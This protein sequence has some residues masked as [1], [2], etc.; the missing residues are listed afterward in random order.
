MY[1]LVINIILNFNTKYI[2]N[3]K[4][5]NHDSIDHFRSFE[6]F[7]VQLFKKS[8]LYRNYILNEQNH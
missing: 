1:N 3:I 6:Q 8:I 4:A 5:I 2:Q 7:S